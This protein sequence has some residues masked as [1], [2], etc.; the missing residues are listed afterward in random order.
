MAEVMYMIPGFITNEVIY[1]GLRKELPIETQVLEF[2]PPNKKES[3]TSYAKRLAEG[4]DQTKPFYLLGTS[5]GGLLSIEISKFLEPEKLI[6]V[7]S[8]KNRDELSFFMKQKWATAFFQIIPAFIIKYVFII[9]FA[10][11]SLFIK[12]YKRINTKEVKQMIGSVDGK[13]EKW[14]MRRISLWDNHNHRKDIIH[15]HGDKDRVFSKKALKTAHVI[16]GGSHSMVIDQY[17]E[18][19]EVIKANL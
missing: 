15:I 17:K 9:G 19:S 8:G 7:S 4:I 5:F 6:I 11:G 16:K 10:I 13:L 1:R 12:S 18:I 14:I 2:I 3:I